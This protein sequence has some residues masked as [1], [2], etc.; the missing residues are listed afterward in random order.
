MADDPGEVR[1]KPTP[2]V[3]RYLGWLA[4]HSIL[5]ETESEVAKNILLQRLAEMR[6][7]DYKE[8][9]KI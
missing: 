5:G 6:G 2:R 8:P 1:F 9:D 7:E 4:R 3:W